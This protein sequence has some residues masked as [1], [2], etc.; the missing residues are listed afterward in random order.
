MPEWITYYQE[1]KESALNII[2]NMPLSSGYQRELTM[3]V[4]KYLDPV[5]LFRIINNERTVVSDPFNKIKLEAEKDLEFTVLIANKRD[6]SNCNI[7]LFE[8]NL[9][10]L[11]NLMLAHMKNSW[12]DNNTIVRLVYLFSV[13]FKLKLIKKM[14]NRCF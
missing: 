4:Q 5:G 3:W 1:N 9:L 10:L 12:M 8:T 11:F 7:L 13:V 6:R 14:I 2:G